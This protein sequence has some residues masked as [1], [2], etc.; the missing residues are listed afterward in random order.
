MG[1]PDFLII[2][3]LDG[4]V[5]LVV[6]KDDHEVW[7]GRCWRRA[8]DDDD[9]DQSNE[10]GERAEASHGGAANVA[11]THRWHRGKFGGWERTKMPVIA[12]EAPPTAAIHGQSDARVGRGLLQSASLLRNDK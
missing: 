1:R 9:R 3:R 8:Q 7:L 6:G 10:G 12:R 11:A 2:Q 4:F 5:A